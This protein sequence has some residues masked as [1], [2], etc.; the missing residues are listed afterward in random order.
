MSGRWWGVAVLLL[1][2]C[3]RDAEQSAAIVTGGDPALG[4]AAISRYGCGSCH[5]IPGVPG[6]T[7]TVGPPLQ[8]LGQRTFLAGRLPNS[9][10]NLMQWVRHPQELEQGTAMPNLDVTEEDARH[11]AA[12]LY[13]LR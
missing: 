9:P 8:A 10:E 6:A 3:K 11:I 12:Y 4:K 2:G 13:T 7:A 5:T 1:A